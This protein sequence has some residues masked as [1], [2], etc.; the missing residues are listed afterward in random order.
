MDL[1]GLQCWYAISIS[2][3][4]D[5]PSLLDPSVTSTHMPG[6]PRSGFSVS[7]EFIDL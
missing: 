7:G 1:G 6:T 3:L 5:P 2:T 4:V